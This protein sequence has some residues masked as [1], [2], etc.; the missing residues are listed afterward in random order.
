MTIWFDPH[1]TAVLVAT[2]ITG[3]IGFPAHGG[4]KVEIKNTGNKT[5]YVRFGDSVVVASTVDYPVIP[6]ET[7]HLLRRL[8]EHTHIAAITDAGSTALSVS[9]GA[10][11]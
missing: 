8:P 3:R 11:S 7:A 9:C 4:Y 2:A 1:V 6:S 5:A 10:E